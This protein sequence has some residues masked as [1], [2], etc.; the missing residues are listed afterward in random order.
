MFDL[1]IAALVL[2]AAFAGW[3]KGFIAPLLAIAVSLLGLYAIYTGPA[4]GAVPTGVA[5]IGLG[6]IFVG[7]ASTFVMRV[8]GVLV[9]LVH[10]VRMLKAAD[11]VLGLPLGAV[12]GLVAVYLGLVAVV[13]FD[14]LLAPFHGKPTVDQAAVAAMRTALAANPQF[15]VMV[16][17]ATLDAM[18]VQV[19]KSAIPADQIGSFDQSLAF[20]E[21]SVRPA[22]IASASAPILLSIGERL[23]FIGRHVEFPTK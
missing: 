9:S 3:R 17:E 23:P 7:I 12:T 2:I 15:S 11:H 22:L 5:G 20:Y 14:N 6:V 1:G 13:S 16:D 10:R 4:A 8:G 18:A 21:T 19:A